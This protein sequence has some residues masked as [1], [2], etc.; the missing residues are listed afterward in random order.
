M[1]RVVS[2]LPG[3]QMASRRSASGWRN[4]QIVVVVYVARSAGHIGVAVSQRKTGARVIEV[5][6]IPGGCGVTVCAI[7]SGENRASGGMRRIVG[8][9][10]GGQMASR[11]SAVRRCDG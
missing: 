10:P 5:C 4:L 6:S 11:I 3:T 8:A 9:L 2:G 7:T 1:N